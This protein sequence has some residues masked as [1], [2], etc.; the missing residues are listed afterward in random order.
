MSGTTTRILPMRTSLALLAFVVMNVGG[1]RVRTALL[2]TRTHMT[3]VINAP[4]QHYTGTVYTEGHYRDASC[5]RHLD[6]KLV[7]DIPYDGCGTKDLGEQFSNVVIIQVHPTMMTADDEIFRVTCNK[8]SLIN[9][10][11]V[12]DS[13]IMGEPPFVN[14]VPKGLF[15]NRSRTILESY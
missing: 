13:F 4:S 15:G 3:V 12:E 2:C 7:F 14:Y 1:T 8:R 6:M 11:L 5:R 10:P 9:A